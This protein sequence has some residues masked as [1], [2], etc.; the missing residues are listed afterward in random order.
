MKIHIVQKGDTLWE[1]SKKYGVDFEEVKKLNSH[2]SSPDMIMP[3]MKIK[4]PSSSKTVKKTQMPKKEMHKEKVKQPYK[5]VSPKPLPVIKEDDKEKK[6]MVKPEMPMKP[7][8]QMPKM[9]EIPTQPIVQQPT[10]E[11]E[12]Q[13]YT[14]I[15]FP[16]MP[17]YSHEHHESVS[18]ESPVDMPVAQPA[19]AHFI[20]MCCHFVHPCYP[21]TPFP[22]MANVASTPMMPMAGGMP[23]HMQ[24]QQQPQH[25]NLGGCG[26]NDQNN[27]SNVGYQAQNHQ[28][29]NT[30]HNMAPPTPNFQSPYH[31]NTMSQTD[32]FPP[33][34]EANNMN[35]NYPMPPGYPYQGYNRENEEGS[36]NE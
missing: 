6:K 20:P 25:S 9:P 13:N 34:Y 19:P 26:C 36:E 23:M 18:D 21:S 28:F 35:N 3:G 32:L 7:L 4:I 16:E 15:N 29:Q 1:I 8:P 2:L 12:F 17:Y 33:Q 31:G 24:P 30:H 22:M 5:D 11:Q 10:F 27:Y 14:T